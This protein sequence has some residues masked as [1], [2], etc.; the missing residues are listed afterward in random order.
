MP[1]CLFI[2]TTNPTTAD[3]GVR[4]CTVSYPGDIIRAH[5]KERGARREFR[6]STIRVTCRSCVTTVGS[7]HFVFQ[8]QPNSLD[9]CLWRYLKTIV[10]S[11]PTEN[12][13]ILQK[14]KCCVCQ[15]IRNRP[16]NCKSLCDSP[17]VLCVD[18]CIAPGGGHSGHWL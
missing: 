18:A 9:F 13:Q 6:Y 17:C 12:E 15:T 5:V 8:V 3:L 14:R 11:A 2:F 4:V 16:G 7:K 10:H 1:Q